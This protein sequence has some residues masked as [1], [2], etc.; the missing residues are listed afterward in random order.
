MKEVTCRSELKRD[1]GE[2]KGLDSVETISSTEHNV[3]IQIYIY[4]YVDRDINRI[5]IYASSLSQS[6]RL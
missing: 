6:V 1:G 5:N 4:T 2:K 3:A